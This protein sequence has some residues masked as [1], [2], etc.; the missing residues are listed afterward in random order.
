MINHQSESDQGKTKSI[1]D[2]SLVKSH[3]QSIKDI[4]LSVYRWAILLLYYLVVLVNGVPYEICVPISS[5]T[6][7]IYN[8]TLALVATASTVFMVMHPILSFVAA[9][10]IS[11]YGWASATN[12]GVILTIAG[13]AIKLLI[14]QAGF[15]VLLIGQ[16][17]CGIGRPFIL[18]SQAS[19]AMSWFHPKTR[20]MIIT[21]LNVVNTLS[22][23]ISAQLPGIIFKGYNLYD[24]PDY[25]DGRSR[26]QS[27]CLLEFYISLAI[28]PSLLMLRSRPKEV[29]VKIN[30]I[31]RKGGMLKIMLRLFKNRNFVLLFIPFSLYFGILKA[32]LVIM[33]LLMAPY[34]YKTDQVAG[35]VSFP[36]IGG[37]I[38]QGAFP[39]FVN[40][41]QIQKP[42]VRLFLL[43]STLAMG[44]LY[45]ALQSNNVIYI[46]IVITLLAMCVMPIL[47]VIMDM[48]CDLISPIEPSFAVGAFYM[49]SMLFFV[50]FTYILTFITGKNK[51]DTRVLYT[52]I[53][54]TIVLIIG[55]LCSL[56]LRIDNQYYALDVEQDK[57]S[58]V[59]PLEKN[60]SILKDNC[61]FIYRGT[62]SKMSIQHQK[63][64]MFSCSHYNISIVGDVPLIPGEEAEDLLDSEQQQ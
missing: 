48:G 2:H 52:N 47:P 57:S 64:S 33:E 11:N 31:E 61:P 49:G 38:A 40:K 28:V 45:F 5:F 26:M 24:D 44:S 27:L 3:T 17:L 20:I 32:Y 16:V 43:S 42:F 7:H 53:F 30:K 1:S 18:N 21:L 23:V 8:V 25:E 58:L 41:Y 10:T 14:N 9:Q 12:L 35:V 15:L 51:E 13:C 34:N 46:Y 60:E 4:D 39:Y 55:L 19:M 36:L 59:H 50:A 37:L 6:A 29:P 62:Q 54:S 22:L 56:F 63:G